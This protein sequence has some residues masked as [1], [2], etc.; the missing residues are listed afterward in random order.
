[1]RRQ[2][3]VPL[4]R[5]G[6]G[7]SKRDLWLQDFGSAHTR[8]V[9]LSSWDG[10]CCTSHRLPSP[11][12]WLARRSWAIGQIWH[13]QTILLWWLKTGCFIFK[14]RK[15]AGES[16]TKFLSLPFFSSSCKKLEWQ[17]NS[18]YMKVILSSKNQHVLVR[19]Y[20]FMKTNHIII[21][22]FVILNFP[23]AKTNRF[24]PH[25]VL[26]YLLR[27]LY[28]SLKCYVKVLGNWPPGS[29]MPPPALLFLLHLH[30]NDTI[31]GYSCEY[32][33]LPKLISLHYVPN[34]RW[35][36]V[37]PLPFLFRLR[38][39]NRPCKASLVTASSKQMP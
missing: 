12:Q 2:V 5:S 9:T 19:L 20:G 13:T 6:G 28:C 18:F 33:A 3:Q 31:R 39:E 24:K 16:L 32:S 1:M 23:D 35:I 4:C 10:A 30:R 26:S 25:P 8:C 37:K 34:F 29:N 15:S 11:Q 27:H 36:L 38:L 7:I 14:S 22:N 21:L 17:K